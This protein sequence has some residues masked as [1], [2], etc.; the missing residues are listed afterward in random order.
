MPLG[1]AG[2]HAVLTAHSGLP[3][4]RLFTDL[5]RLE[6]GDEFMV[7]TLGQVAHYR[8]DQITTVQPNSAD[9]LRQVPGKDYV[10][11]LTCTPTGVNTHRLLVRGERIPAQEASEAA[12]H[13]PAH[14]SDPGFPWWALALVGTLVL[15]GWIARPRRGL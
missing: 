7:E 1:G 4:A 13:L 10:T 14:S 9:E 11:L 3:H 6:V 15:A 12:Q 8:V 2:T 5:G